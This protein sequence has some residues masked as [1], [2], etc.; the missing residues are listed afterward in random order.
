MKSLD[1]SISGGFSMGGCL[2]LHSGY[3]LN[4]QLAGVFA[5]SS[6]LNND[7]IVFNTL[8]SN[9]NKPNIELP[10]LLMYHGERDSLVPSS[11]GKESYD[12]LI[13]LGVQGDFR[14]LK[15]TLHEL[16]ANQLLEL[17]DWIVKLLPP[18]DKDLQN[19]L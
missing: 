12:E 3:H 19:K 17:H 7:S 1:I 4:N 11:W 6:F 5:L 18:L 10:K 15:N 14:S 16:K 2:A 13:S 9:Q 8:R